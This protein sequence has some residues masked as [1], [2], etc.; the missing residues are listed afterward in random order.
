MRAYCSTCDRWVRAAPGTPCPDCG[1][2]DTMPPEAKPARTPRGE[3][4]NTIQRVTYS[5]NMTVC[6]LCWDE[7]AEVRLV[8]AKGR[9]FCPHHG[10]LETEAPK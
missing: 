4:A 6:P 7:A 8:K 2:A 9:M 5:P 1:T 3:K 10:E